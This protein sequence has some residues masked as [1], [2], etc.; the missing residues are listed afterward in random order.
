MSLKVLCDENIP[1]AIAASLEQWG[2]IVE[3]VV[4]GM[5]DSEVARM[6]RDKQSILL[7]FDSDFANILAYPPG[8]FFGIIRINIEPPTIDV[9]LAS[10]A[11]IFD[12]FETSAD[13]KGKLIIADEGRFR[14][15]GNK[16]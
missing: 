4:P 9:V 5:K 8:E 6:A 10:L 16:D 11:Y 2:F 14:V 12:F 7:T 15:W 1:H 3:R 13:F